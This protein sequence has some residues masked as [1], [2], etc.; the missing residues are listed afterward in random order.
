MGLK[1]SFF[2]PSVS[3]RRR[4]PSADE[5]TVP[6]RTVGEDSPGGATRARASCARISQW[7]SA[8]AAATEQL[9]GDG[10]KPLP[11]KPQALR[12]TLGE[13]GQ[14]VNVLPTHRSSHLRS[15]LP[16]LVSY[17][18]KSVSEPTRQS[19]AGF[20]MAAARPSGNGP[21]MLF[22][23]K[24]ILVKALSLPTEGGILPVKLLPSQ[25]ISSSSG[26]FA[27]MSGNSPLRP[28]ACTIRWRSQPVARS[29]SGQPAAAVAERCAAGGGV[30]RASSEAR[31]SAPRRRTAKV[32]VEMRQVCQHR[33]S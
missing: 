12:S 7:P 32:A 27:S 20:C 19:F 22:K 3:R 23:L 4:P 15:G 8:V 33:E 17:G 16:A 10:V 13:S 1:P 11:C 18:A 30:R 24:L 28:A 25:Y 6:A 14:S 21:D 29:P 5:R 26:L 31:R 9:S 2:Y